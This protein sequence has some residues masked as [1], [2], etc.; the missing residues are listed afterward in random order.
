MKIRVGDLVRIKSWNQMV[1]EYGLE[2][3]DRISTPRPFNFIS[4]MKP[5]CGLVARV[6]DKGS[7][8]LLLGG[9]P[10]VERFLSSHGYEITASMVTKVNKEDYCI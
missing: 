8:S 2:N 3:P 4:P 9:N 7:Y 10:V 5:L 6:I 1:K